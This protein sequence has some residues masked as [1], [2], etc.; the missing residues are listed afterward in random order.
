MI[1]GLPLAALTPLSALCLVLALPYLQMA[2]GRLH[3][4]ST[5]DR[6]QADHAREVADI[7]HDRNEWRAAH[8]ISET[9]RQVAADQVDELLEHARTTD[10]FIRALPHPES[11]GKP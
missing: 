2:R 11:M 7:V 8:R 6:M 5:I 9:A 10:A 1:E 4:Q 3:P